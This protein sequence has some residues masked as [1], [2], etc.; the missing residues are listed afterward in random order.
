M[1]D[2][3]AIAADHELTDA[4]EAPEV[5]HIDAGAPSEAVPAATNGAV[6]TT[7]EITGNNEVLSTV[8]AHASPTPAFNS[9]PYKP[10]PINVLPKIVGNFVSEAAA[11]IGCDPSF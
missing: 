7:D 8:S 3:I 6:D 11:A 5:A 2:S 4:M 1:N 9:A 10:F